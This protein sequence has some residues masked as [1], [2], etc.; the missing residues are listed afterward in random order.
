[1]QEQAVDANQPRDAPHHEAADVEVT[2]SPP[3]LGP[4]TAAPYAM[5]AERKAGNR[6]RR[7]GADAL[8]AAGGAMKWKALRHT[9]RVQVR[10]CM[11]V[12]WGVWI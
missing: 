3:L 6:V 2:R 8:A 4:G 12:W 10:I 11:S 9:V 7:L 1:M 5:G